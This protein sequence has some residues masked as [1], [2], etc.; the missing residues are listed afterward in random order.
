[1]DYTFFVAFSIGLLSIVHCLGMCSGIVGAL[2]FSLPADVQQN[3][4]RLF[5]FI[6]SYNLGRIFSYTIAGAI[7][8][9]ASK[10]LF[11]FISPQ[12]GHKVLQWISA[13][14]L[15][16]IGMH[17]SGWFS[18]L[19]LIERLGQPLWRILEPVG[20][21]MLPV[22]SLPQA[23][24]FGAIWGWLPCGLVYSALIWASSAGNSLQSGLLMLMFGLG[25]LP[26][27]VTAGILT[28]WLRELTQQ[29]N[30]RRLAGL[31]LIALAI[32]SPYYALGPE[33]HNHNKNS[34]FTW[35]TEHEP[36]HI[37]P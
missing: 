33:H 23:F 13:A 30:F 5:P 32:F 21:R 16:L 34:E 25:T 10:E 2:S 28:N 36:T 12:Y 31:L 3:R 22:K 14:V 15:L 11:S 24:V 35:G 18:R 1:L 19:N 20:R 27:V 17:V 37:Q 26:T 8:G 7:L 29:R 4:Q 6:L 9:I